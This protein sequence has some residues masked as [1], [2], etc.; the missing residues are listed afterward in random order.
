[1]PATTSRPSFLH[2]GHSSVV[3]S[4]TCLMTCLNAQ[5]ASN[6]TRNRVRFLRQIGANGSSAKKLAYLKS[7]LI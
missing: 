7:C 5:N 2:S 3:R 6:Q 4:K 1:M